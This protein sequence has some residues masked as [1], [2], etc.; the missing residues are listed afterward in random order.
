MSDAMSLLLHAT[1]LKYSRELQHSRLFSCLIVACSPMGGRTGPLH[2]AAHSSRVSSITAIPSFFWKLPKCADMMWLVQAVQRRASFIVVHYAWIIV[3]SL[4][5]LVVL[6]PEGN[7]AAV[8]AYFFGASAS[9]ESGLNTVDVKELRTYEQVFLYVVPTIT[10]L[11]IINV[12]VVIVRILWFKRKFR[13]ASLTLIRAE[14][15]GVV[16]ALR[17]TGDGI[18]AQNQAV[19]ASEARNNATG[20]M[21]VSIMRSN[22]SQDLTV[23]VES[24]EVDGTANG[25]GFQRQAATSNDAHHVLYNSPPHERDDGRSFV[26][27][28]FHGNGPLTGQDLENEYDSEEIK[29]VRQIYKGEPSEPTY[30]LSSHSRNHRLSKEKS[31]ENVAGSMFVQGSRPKEGRRSDASQFPRPNDLPGLSK[32]VTIGRSSKFYDLSE[33]DEERLGG[34]EYVALKLLLKVVIGYYIGLHLIGVIGLVPWIHTAP[35]QY[36]EFLVECGQDWTWWAIYSTQTMVNNLGFTL[37]PDSMISFRDATWPM[38]LMTFLAFAGN[39][40]YPVMLRF[41]IWVMYKTTSSKSPTKA[42]LKFLLD[43]P[44]RCYTLLFPS[45]PTWILFGIIAALNIVDVILIIVLDLDNPTITDLPMGP[46]ILAALFQAASSRH[47]GTS[48]MNLA[49]INPAVQF[50]LVVIMYI[51]ILPIAISI[52]ASNTYEEQS[53][54]IYAVEHQALDET[55]TSSYFMMHVRNQLSFDLWYIFL[56]TFCLCIAESGRIADNSEPAFSVFSIFF[57]VVSAYGNVG[58]SLGHPSVST[59]LCGLFGVFGKLVICAMMIRGRHRCLPYSIDRAIML[60]GEAP[61]VNRERTGDGQMSVRRSSLGSSR[62]SSRRVP[63]AAEAFAH[64][65]PEKVKAP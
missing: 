26:E 6:A 2:P 63:A 18:E 38:L 8:D 49:E 9:T 52:R 39:T 41:C 62:M 36:R 43:H 55:R 28:D 58:L 54:G 11:G 13:A 32:Q 4:M 23:Q 61:L 50:S 64:P 42:T 60:P 1:G 56:G 37:T 19:P 51:A 46:R 21:D 24:L 31:I 10:N 14:P 57:E 5:G 30:Q 16:F 15:K 59:S 27:T 33:E 34:I 3:C 45:R 20:E 17:R 22:P 40:L 44:R 25:T 48:T 53:L 12:M 29:Q 65:R 7:M 47:T 35:D